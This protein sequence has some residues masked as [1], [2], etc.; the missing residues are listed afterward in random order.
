MKKL[1]ALVPAAPT[2]WK[3]DE[4]LVYPLASSTCRGATFQSVSY[5]VSYTNLS[6]VADANRRA[7]A[8]GR[9]VAELRQASR[10]ARS[11]ANGPRSGRLATQPPA[12][13]SKR[14]SKTSTAAGPPSAG[15]TKK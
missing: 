1:E 7:E 13:I 3:L 2:G 5:T 6:R 4:P 14:A 9:Q 10:A 15:R 8:M 11:S 12:P